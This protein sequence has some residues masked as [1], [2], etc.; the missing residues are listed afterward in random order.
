M[1][2]GKRVSP[3]TLLLFYTLG[4]NEVR[5]RKKKVYSTNI[6]I[7]VP[8]TAVGSVGQNTRAETLSLVSTNE[9]AEKSLSFM[10]LNLLFMQKQGDVFEV[11][12]IKLTSTSYFIKVSKVTNSLTQH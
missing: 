1:C 4:F 7:V 12:K 6:I 3:T 2:N 5:R 8:H 11:I 9:K 10:G